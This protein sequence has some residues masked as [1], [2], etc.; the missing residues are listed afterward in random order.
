[1]PTFGPS[2]SH[3]FKELAEKFQ[4]SHVTEGL[5]PEQVKMMNFTYFPD[6]QE[7]IERVSEGLPRAVVAIFPSGGK[8]IPEVTKRKG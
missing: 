4:V 7:A 2:K 6:L 3:H 8:N 1:M 5:F